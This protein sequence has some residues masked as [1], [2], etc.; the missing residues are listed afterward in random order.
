MI[1][2]YWPVFKNIEKE[3]I[4]LSYNIYF[5]DKQFEY[6]EE[7]NGNFSKSPPYSLKIGELLIRCCTEIEALIKEL[8]LGKE[9][10]IK[11]LPNVDGNRNI[12][13]G[14]R[15]KYLFKT[16]GIDDKIVIVS[17]NNMYFKRN[18]NKSFF[19]FKYTNNS[20]DDYYS[21]YNAIKHNRNLETLHKGN[22]RNLLRALAAL[23]ILNLFYKKD[24]ISLD[25]NPN[26]VPI[27]SDIFSVESLKASM[28]E[29]YGDVK[30]IYSNFE[31]LKRSVYLVKKSASFSEKEY[32]IIDAFNVEVN[33]KIAEIKLKNPNIEHMKAIEIAIQSSKT[34]QQ[35]KESNE[36]IEYEAVIVN[37]KD[38]NFYVSI[39]CKEKFTN[40]E[41]KIIEKDINDWKLEY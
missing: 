22:I 6:I 40:E 24:S 26:Y 27:N 37:P 18:E 12:T 11:R 10:S 2:L 30:I 17:S 38:I 36:K 4:E 21:S 35:L 25:R 9:S 28:K 14:C 34:G 16:Y 41:L 19:P 7:E 15:L 23:Y 8:T 5:D 1:N 13:N 20:I 29:K 3:V 39:G 32:Q 31:A 33:R